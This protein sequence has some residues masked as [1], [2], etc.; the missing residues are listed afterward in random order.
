MTDEDVEFGD[1][2]PE[3]VAAEE[4]TDVDWSQVEK[5][6]SQIDSIE[7]IERDDERLEAARKWAAELEGGG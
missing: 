7:T 6:A 4:D 2:E 3:D 5:L 1:I